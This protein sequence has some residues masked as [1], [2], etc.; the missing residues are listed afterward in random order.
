V[1]VFVSRT[2]IK[3]YPNEST[4]LSP[5][6][7]SYNRI[8]EHSKLQDKRMNMGAI[9]SA[10]SKFC[11]LTRNTNKLLREGVGRNV[12]DIELMLLTDDHKVR[13]P[14]IKKSFAHSVLLPTSEQSLGGV[15]VKVPRC[16]EQLLTAEYTKGWRTPLVYSTLGRKLKLQPGQP[17]YIKPSAA[18][19]KLFKVVAPL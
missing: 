4:I 16:P 19:V 17:R 18:L 3:V 6:R 5:F 7:E 13:C 14:V 2:R 9:A 8:A 12:L 10:A 15:L 11:T 1:I